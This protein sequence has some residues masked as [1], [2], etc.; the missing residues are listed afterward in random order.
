MPSSHNGNRL[1]E[2]NLTLMRDF[3]FCKTDLPMENESQKKPGDDLCITPGSNGMTATDRGIVV[4]AEPVTGISNVMADSVAALPAILGAADILR[5]GYLSRITLSVTDYIPRVAVFAIILLAGL[6]LTDYLIRVFRAITKDYAIGLIAPALFLIR[7][8]LYFSVVMLALSQ[9]MIDPAAVC[10]FLTPV[11]WGA[12]TGAGA[13]IAISV[14]Y[15]GGTTAIRSQKSS[16]GCY[17]SK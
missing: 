16:R 14:F 17:P 1:Q 13:A 8:F 9:L 5:L 3:R 11:A 15:G 10:L 6:I 4:A 7:I 12:G 2:S